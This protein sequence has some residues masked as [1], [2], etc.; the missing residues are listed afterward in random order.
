MQ[1]SIVWES[2]SSVQILTEVDEERYNVVTGGLS[3]CV[4]ETL[5]VTS[6]S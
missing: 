4:V 6:N 3:W 1:C 5:A 2:V